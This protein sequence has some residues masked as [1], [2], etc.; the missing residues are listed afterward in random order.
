MRS[1]KE[2]RPEGR[3][4][5]GQRTRDKKERKMRHKTERMHTQKE[6]EGRG[7]FS[8]RHKTS[9]YVVGIIFAALL[10]FGLGS[11]IFA[12]TVALP[13]G[14]L[15]WNLRSINQYTA[16]SQ[17]VAKSGL[18]KFSSGGVTWE[19]KVQVGNIYLVSDTDLGWTHLGNTDVASHV[20][21][22]KGDLLAYT[23]NTYADQLPGIVLETHLGGFQYRYAYYGFFGDLANLQFPRPWSVDALTLPSNWVDN[24]QATLQ[25]NIGLDIQLDPSL[26]VGDIPKEFNTTDWSYRYSGL[27]AGILRANA[28]PVIEAGTG[29]VRQPGTT[30][31]DFGFSNPADT[32]ILSSGVTPSSSVPALA[33]DVQSYI[34]IV[35]TTGRRFNVDKVGSFTKSG[36]S[37]SIANAMG[38]GDTV[39]LFTYDK[40]ETF[41][42]TFTYDMLADTT[43]SHVIGYVPVTMRPATTITDTTYKWNY[44]SVENRYWGGYSSNN[45]LGQTITFDT[46]VQ[47]DN[48]FVVQPIQFA[49]MVSTNYTAVP[50]QSSEDANNPFYEPPTEP[51]N[52]EGTNNTFTN[53]VTG[54]I[55]DVSGNAPLGIMDLIRFFAQN[56]ILILVVIV[57]VC[58]VIYVI[59]KRLRGGGGS[60]ARESPTTN[61]IFQQPT[62]SGTL[63]Q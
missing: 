33:A 29:V 61:V 48:V 7:R 4:R 50:L 43:R 44:F 38:K 49:V 24:L 54:K 1:P 63:P 56:W 28:D 62:G 11:M 31:T 16:G 14:F 13:S 2:H 37:G 3:G 26:L 60:A 59:Y 19:G 58:V 35:D 39:Q 18:Y 20:F 22:F 9:L 12:A 10:I 23:L 51:P 52:V 41:P 53:A 17:E 40:N 36:S 46:A 5:K 55:T 57:V 25:M 6:K 34:D 21:W 27:W 8:S 30:I 45:I 47:V 15:S 42:T 32:E